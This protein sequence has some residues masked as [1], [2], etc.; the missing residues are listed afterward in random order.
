MVAT[1]PPSPP[2]PTLNITHNT[3]PSSKQQFQESL[4]LPIP[5][6]LSIPPS[7]AYSLSPS[8]FFS[9]L[10]IL[11]LSLWQMSFNKSWQSDEIKGV[12]PI[13]GYS[14]GLS[15]ALTY[16]KQGLNSVARMCLTSPGCHNVIK[17]IITAWHC[18]VVIKRIHSHHWHQRTWAFSGPSVLVPTVTPIK[19]FIPLT[20]LVDIRPHLPCCLI[21]SLVHKKGVGT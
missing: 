12:Y 13:A 17:I 10:F 14:S 15:L 5:S 3:C 6:S 18:I 8:A 9:L 16:L 4:C 7:F 2:S 20:L 11:S 1:H 19:Q 21:T